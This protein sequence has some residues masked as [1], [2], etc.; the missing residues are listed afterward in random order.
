MKATILLFLSM[1]IV[2]VCYAED[3]NLKEKEDGD[4]KNCYQGYTGFYIS[5]NVGIRPYGYL[6]FKEKNDEKVNIYSVI[7]FG[8][9]YYNKPNISIGQDWVFNK[10]L[11]GP[12]IS[13]FGYRD[14]FQNYLPEFRLGYELKNIKIIGTTYWNYKDVEVSPMIWGKKPL[15]KVTIGFFYNFNLVN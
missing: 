14:I 15:A 3:F 13:F 7:G 5:N 8:V 12:G 2:F 4:L 1:F 9:N 6:R 10:V 11:I